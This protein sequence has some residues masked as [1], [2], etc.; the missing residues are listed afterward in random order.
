MRLASALACVLALSTTAAA[1]QPEG[2]KGSAKALLQSGLKL[3]AAKDYLGALAVFKDAYA[4]FPSGKI[5]LNIGTTL[6]KLDRPAEA[7]NAYQRYLDSPDVDASKKDEAI[8]ALAELDKK[9]ALVE[10]A[11][12]PAD[13]E[14]QLNTEE[15]R[16]AADVKR[17]RVM[18]GVASIRARREGYK[19]GETTVSAPANA[20]TNAELTLQAEAKAVASTTTTTT[21][22][23]V[24]GSTEIGGTF[25]RDDKQRARF[26][27]LVLA[28]VDPSNQGAAAIVGGTADVTSRI[29]V[30]AGAILGPQYG[31]YAGANVAILT[32]RIRPIVAVAMPI[33]YSNGWRPAVRG[34]GGVEV[35]V[36]R[37]L[38]LIA[39]LG[40][41]HV[42]SAEA[43]IESP[44]LFIPAVGVAGR[45]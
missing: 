32:G 9:V 29:A 10:L 2:D 18:P 11:I 3:Y 1:Q 26:G 30:R 28:H 24:D 14:V 31:G 36:N 33:F 7:A 34:A 40:V 22:A 41:E 4:R 25:V 27:V 39:E 37:H 12:E 15:W 8:R 17:T 19:Q 21:P 5:L 23:P 45:L 35:A 20:T 6:I 38:A 16:P 44:T 42:F 43:S 13:A